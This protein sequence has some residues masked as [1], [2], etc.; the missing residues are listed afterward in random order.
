MQAEE[1]KPGDQLW[2]RARLVYTVEHVMVLPPH[3]IA[4]VRYTDGGNAERMWE[5]GKDAQLTRP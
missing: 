5:I 1:I 4:T 3:V 2:D